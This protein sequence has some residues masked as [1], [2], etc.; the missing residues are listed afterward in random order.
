MN[1]GPLNTAGGIP[2]INLD[3]SPSW[4]LMPVKWTSMYWSSSCQATV[5]SSMSAGTA[6]REIKGGS[7]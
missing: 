5:P 4:D 1:R 6:G 7:I 3:Y 2:T